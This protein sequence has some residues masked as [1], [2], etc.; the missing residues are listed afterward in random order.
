[1]MSSLSRPMPEQPAPLGWPDGVRHRSDYRTCH[2]HVP[3]HD[4]PVAAIAMA[5]QFYSLFK[6]QQSLDAA[7]DLGH[8][9][10]E[11]GDRAVITPLPTGYAVWVW[12]PEAQPLPAR[13]RPVADPFV[14]HRYQPCH[15]HVPHRADRLPAIRVQAQYYSLFR[16]VNRPDQAQRVSAKLGDRGHGVMITKTIRGYAL[17]LLEPEAVL[18]QQP[19]AVS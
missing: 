15:I 4:R 1:M 19:G 7:I 13:P 5:G 11:Q 12:E 18:A 17:W 2:I 14:Q 3:D 9:L 16:I 8:R 10:Q 6:A